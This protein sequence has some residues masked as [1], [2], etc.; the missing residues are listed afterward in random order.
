MAKQHTQSCGLDCNPMLTL[1]FLFSLSLHLSLSHECMKFS[2]Q[3]A[4][5]TWRAGMAG[6]SV[7]VGDVARGYGGS[8]KMGPK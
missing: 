3:V 8:V 4:I 7:S 1:S 2:K 5:A 6:K